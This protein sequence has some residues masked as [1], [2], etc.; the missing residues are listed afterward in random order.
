MSLHFFFSDFLYKS[1]CFGYSFE[2]HQEV[3][4][5]YTGCNQKTTELL[6]YVL[7]RVCAVIRST[8]VIM[9]WRNLSGYPLI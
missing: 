8:I 7:I 5:I 6:D 3:N 9:L 2:L 1:I 4:K